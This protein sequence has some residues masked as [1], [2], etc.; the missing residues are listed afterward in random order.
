MKRTIK[1]CITLLALALV[2]QA[3]AVNYTVRVTGSTAYRAATHKAIIS[4]LGGN[5][6]TGVPVRMAHSGSASTDVGAQGAN[7]ATYIAA[8]GSDNYTIQCNFTGSVEGI[9]DVGLGTAIPFIPASQ[10]PALD[11]FANA[12]RVTPVGTNPPTNATDIQVANFAFSDV[13]KQSTDYSTVTLNTPDPVGIIPFVWVANRGSTL[14]NMTAQQARALFT[15]GYVRKNLFTGL[16]ADDPVLTPATGSYVVITGRNP[17]SGTRVATLAETQHGV[18]STVKQYKVNATTGT[19]GGSGGTDP[20]LTTLELWPAYGTTGDVDP[21]TGNGGY[22]SGGTIATQMA[23]QGASVNLVF[24]PDPEND[25][26]TT[27]PLLSGKKIDLVS[28]LGVSDAATATNGTNQGVRLTWH[29]NSYTGSS[30]NDNIIYGRYTFWSTVQLYTKGTL[31]TGEGNFKTALLTFLNNQSNIGS[32]SIAIG[33][34]KV[35]RAT[36]GG[37]VGF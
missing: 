9:R 7:W 32:S 8:V 18:F 37:L 31:N 2:Q 4:F 27:V 17:L 35:S 14:T 15:N 29:G 10:V 24:C 3:S 34:M 30:Q 5:A 21:V 13:V 19:A 28:Y 23:F 33:T 11:G 22:T 16:I 6:T 36:D 26:G 25:P 12:V 20:Q 1:S